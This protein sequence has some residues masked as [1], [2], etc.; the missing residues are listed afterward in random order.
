MKKEEFNLTTNCGKITKEFNLTKRN[1][2]GEN[3]PHWKGI[4]TKEMI[5][6][7]NI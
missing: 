1:Y 7:R 2:D 6:T 3:N 4:N 5:I